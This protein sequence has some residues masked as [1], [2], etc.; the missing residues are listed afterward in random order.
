MREVTLGRDQSVT[1][2]VTKR[3]HRDH[4]GTGTKE[5]REEETLSPLLSL[6]FSFVACSDSQ[7]C[8]VVVTLAL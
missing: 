4:D 7:F 2:G 8:R 5:E 6:R 1:R 3:D